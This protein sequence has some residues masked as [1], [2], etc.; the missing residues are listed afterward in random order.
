LY[1]STNHTRSCEIRR[2]HEFYS[3]LYVFKHARKPERTTHALYI[4]QRR[5]TKKN[6]FD[7][8]RMSRFA[9]MTHTSFLSRKR[10][11]TKYVTVEKQASSEAKTTLASTIQ[12]ERLLVLH[13]PALENHACAVYHTN[14]CDKYNRFRGKTYVKVCFHDAHVFFVTEEGVDKVRD[15]G[16]ASVFGN[17]DNAC[18]NHPTRTTTRITRTHVLHSANGLIRTD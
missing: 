18:I 2:T 14:A 7:D 8:K 1:T 12:R 15:R 5:V 4:T 9:F 6:G 13:A 17:K 11:L 10:M 3:R 16:K